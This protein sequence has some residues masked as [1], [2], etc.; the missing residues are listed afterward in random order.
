[1]YLDVKV[2]IPKL[3]GKIIRKT[4]GGST[5]IYYEYGRTYDK[6]RKFAIPKR[7]I[8]GKLDGDGM[9]VPNENFRKFLPNEKLPGETARAARSG[10][11]RIG[12]YII[13]RKIMDGY[14]LPAMLGEIFTPGDLGLFLDLA[15]YSIV[16]ENN[17]AQHYPDY[18][19]NHPLFTAGMRQYSVTKVSDF[20]TSMPR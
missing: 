7:I 4:K 13:V 11:I 20:L 10:C 9:L 14:R 6:A 17:A 1:M 3:P 15:A 18:A 8:I 19:Y 16:C 12:A 5:Y 2:E